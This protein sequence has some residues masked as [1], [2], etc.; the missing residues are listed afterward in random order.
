MKGKPGSASTGG[1]DDCSPRY[2][3]IKRIKTPI[4]TINPKKS[5]IIAL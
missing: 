3:V 4:K 5:E 2:N 1:D